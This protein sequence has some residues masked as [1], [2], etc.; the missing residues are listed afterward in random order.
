MGN[1]I[2]HSCAL[3]QW[4]VS[5]ASI[6]RDCLFEVVQKSSHNPVTTRCGVWLHQHGARPPRLGNGLM[7]NAALH[8]CEFCEFFPFVRHC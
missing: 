8:W 6:A 7:I 3:F 5:G 2:L 1:R 4:V